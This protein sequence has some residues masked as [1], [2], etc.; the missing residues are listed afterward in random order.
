M[1]RDTARTDVW[2][3]SRHKRKAV[4]KLFTHLKLILGLDRL[5]LRGPNGARESS[6]SQPLHR[7]PQAGQADP[8]GRAGAGRARAAALARPTPVSTSASARN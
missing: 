3:V 5:R 4:E 7:T 2:L 1:A 8:A 6:T